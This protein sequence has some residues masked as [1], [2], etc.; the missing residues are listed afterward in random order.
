MG[1]LDRILG[2]K[3]NTGDQTLPST[4]EEYY[5]LGVSGYENFD[6]GWRE[7]LEK[8]YSLGSAKAARFLGRAAEKDLQFSRAE[9]WYQNGYAI[10]RALCAPDFGRLYLRSWDGSGRP[11]NLKKAEYFLKMAADA[12]DETSASLLE[13]LRKKYSNPDLISPQQ[14][15]AVES[16][17]EN[18]IRN[19]YDRYHTE[20]E[21]RKRVD[22]IISWLEDPN[23]LNFKA[24]AKTAA[25]LNF[26]LFRADMGREFFESVLHLKYDPNWELLLVVTL[27]GEREIDTAQ[28]LS[29]LHNILDYYS[30]FPEKAEEIPSFAEGAGALC[31]AI[32]INRQ[33]LEDEMLREK[34]LVPVFDSIRGIYPDLIRLFT[35]SP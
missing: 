27:L 11:Q 14:A 2:K 4:A 34:A 21:D 24:P 17:A 25:L 33:R 28:I 6:A 26:R 8:A 29:R 20:I 12:G 16:F 30:D 15:A 7:S 19:G 32:E 10:D 9:K 5:R 1:F 35:L 13:E 3:Q 31:R 23:Q 22:T 18:V